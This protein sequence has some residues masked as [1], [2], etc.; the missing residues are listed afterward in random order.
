VPPRDWSFRVEDIVAAIER[1]LEYTRG[2]DAKSLA[3]TPQTF[4]AVL[5][6]F[7]VIGEAAAHVP[8]EVTSRFPEIDWKQMRG[9][10]NRLVHEYFGADPEIVWQTVRDD[11]PALLPRL[12]SILLSS[13]TDD[14][15]RP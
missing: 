15:D 5:F 1:V 2:M 4:E 8:P 9:L 6:N 7:I 10:R 12:R 13:D 14:P 11:L 3:R